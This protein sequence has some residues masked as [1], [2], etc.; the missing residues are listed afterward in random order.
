MIVPLLLFGCSAELAS[1]GG[2]NDEGAVVVSKDEFSVLGYGGTRVAAG[3]GT[4]RGAD[5]VSEPEGCGAGVN[6]G[7]AEA[8][9]VGLPADGKPGPG[10]RSAGVAGAGGKAGAPGVSSGDVDALTLAG[11]ATGARFGDADP[12]G[13][14]SGL[15][16]RLGD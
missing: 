1:D 9:V 11:G 12:A 10:V 14:R 3:E 15:V 5:D 6:N 16:L 7:A 4:S 13:A 8:S 2:S